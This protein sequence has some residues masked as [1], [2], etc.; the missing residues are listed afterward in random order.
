MRR[1][2]GTC[3]TKRSIGGRVP[4]GQPTVRRVSLSFPG[5][6]DYAL[7]RKTGVLSRRVSQAALS[8]VQ[9]SSHS[10]SVTGSLVGYGAVESE[11]PGGGG[12]RIEQSRTHEQSGHSWPKGP[13]QRIR[14]L[15]N[16]R[17]DGRHRDVS[18]SGRQF[19]TKCVCSTGQSKTTADNTPD[20]SETACPRAPWATGWR[21]GGRDA[22]PG[23]GSLEPNLHRVEHR[24][25][26]YA[27]Q[28]A[29]CN[30]RRYGARPSDPNQGRRTGRP[31]KPRCV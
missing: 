5:G 22:L 12:L 25:F 14:R 19:A 4:V 11:I 1:Y 30:L 21:L 28:G 10:Q 7:Y 3:S 18:S 24:T 13:K 27:S 29:Q 23:V 8:T 9:N 20:R 31:R 2:R 16:P 26:R 17:N 6:T 15:V